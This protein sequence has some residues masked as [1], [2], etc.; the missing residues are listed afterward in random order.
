MEPKEEEL[1]ALS[2]LIPRLAGAIRRFMARDLAGYG[3]TAPQCMA[4]MVLDSA[5]GCARMG[6]LAEGARQSSAA[7]T[8]IV[9]RLCERGLVE[10]QRDPKDRRSVVVRLTDAGKELL[11][12]IREEQQERMRAV[13]LRLSPQERRQ[14]RAAVEALIAAIEGMR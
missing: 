12:R 14:L 11:R 5:E 4:L 3:L 10:R 13:F 8:G 6:M 9:D 7:M 2:A 1:E